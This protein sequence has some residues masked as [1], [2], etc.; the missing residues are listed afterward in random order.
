[1]SAAEPDFDIAIFGAG[2]VGAA[3]ALLLAR[4]WPDPARLL[5]VDARPAGAA[6][7]DP[8]ALAISEGSLQLLARLIDPRELA[9]APIETVHV[10]QRGHFGRTLLSASEMGVAALGRVVRYRDL[11]AP[12]EIAL[13]ASGVRIARPATVAPQVTESGVRL[14]LPD[15]AVEA[16]L[17]VHAEGGVFERTAVVAGSEAGA[18]MSRAP[19]GAASANSARTAPRQR[20]YGQSAVICEVEASQPRRG[21]A[22]ERFTRG[23]PIALL[24]VDDGR[25]QSLVWCAAPDDAARIAALD[26]MAFLAALGEA[27]GSRVG[28][29]RAAGP[30]HVY[31]L[32]QVRRDGGGAREVGIG[33][34]AQILHPVAGQGFN[35][36]LRDAAALADAL[37]MSA[38]TPRPGAATA[39]TAAFDPRAAFDPATALAAYRA[40]RRLDRDFVLH[41]TDALARLFTLPLPGATHAAGAAIALLDLLPALRR[42]VTRA[43]MFGLR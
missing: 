22:F 41:A 8:R 36:G 33:N 3:F 20:D 32:G 42:P 18:A 19:A 28:Q 10:S 26:D 14:D 5:V 2:P 30:R 13:A 43:L 29:F 24:P 37:A 11:M 27:F 12:L 23:G 6:A 17:L 9:S 39:T 34:A 16:A 1:M 31:A 7:A 38:S 21:W 40:A 25:R 35:L 4:V 15:G